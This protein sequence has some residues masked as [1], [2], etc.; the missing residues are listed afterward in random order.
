VLEIPR[1]GSPVWQWEAGGML[2]L[3]QSGADDTV[4]LGEA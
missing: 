2:P 4:P 1:Y 3:H